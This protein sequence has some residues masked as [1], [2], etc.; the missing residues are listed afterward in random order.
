MNT[1]EWTEA[2]D[3][4]WTR[5]GRVI[6]AGNGAEIVVGA[7]WTEED[8]LQVSLDTPE[9]GFIPAAVAPKVAS[10]LASLSLGRPPVGED[11]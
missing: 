8:G 3:G 7:V 6:D 11:P 9:D 4:V 10:A 2:G 1:Q 5:A